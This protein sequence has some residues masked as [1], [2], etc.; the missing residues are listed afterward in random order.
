MFS[1]D[2]YN[3]S[4]SNIY[5]TNTTRCPKQKHT[6]FPSLHRTFEKWSCTRPQTSPTKSPKLTSYRYF[7]W[8]LCNQIINQQFK[9][10]SQIFHVYFIDLVLK[11]ILNKSKLK[12]KN[13]RVY[14]SRESKTASDWE[15]K[16]KLK[17]QTI[18]ERVYI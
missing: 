4:Y 16:F 8:Q 13:S 11:A 3:Y 12:K 17:K 1:Y 6:F 9:E 18:L 2:F 7:F 5:L 14:E 10:S 15:M